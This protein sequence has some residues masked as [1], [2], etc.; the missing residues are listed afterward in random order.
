MRCGAGFNLNAPGA[1]HLHHKRDVL[2]ALRSPAP[3]G[4]VIDQKGFLHGWIILVKGRIEDLGEKM[5]KAFIAVSAISI[6]AT[7]LFILNHG[8]GGGHGKYDSALGILGLPWLLLPLPDFL[9]KRDFVWLIL[10][11]L[12]C[13]LVSVL[14]V[15]RLILALSRK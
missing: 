8:F 11:P 2:R 7:L 14:A 6:L 15:S 5:K 12:M 10:V 13:N 1:Q 4:R 3:G 9:Y